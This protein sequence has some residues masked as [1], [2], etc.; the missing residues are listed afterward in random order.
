M[1]IRTGKE[2]K[3]INCLLHVIYIN[4]GKNIGNEI[5]EICMNCKHAH[6]SQYINEIKLQGKMD[7]R[8]KRIAHQG[9]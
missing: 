8:Y 6:I 1:K 9:A 5:L 7:N 3:K 2:C 4:S